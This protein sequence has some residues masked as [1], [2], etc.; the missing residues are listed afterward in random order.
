MKGVRGRGRRAGRLRWACFEL[1]LVACSLRHPLD[2]PLLAMPIGPTSTS[3]PKKKAPL[4][5]WDAPQR[6]KKATELEVRAE[7]KQM[8]GQD[9][10]LGRTSDDSK[11]AEGKKAIKP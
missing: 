8:E 10:V 3:A 5:G 6:P 11:Q 2:L 4:D 9:R 1:R 7:L